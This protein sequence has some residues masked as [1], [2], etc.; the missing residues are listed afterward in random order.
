MVS[1]LGDKRI[2]SDSSS[3][4]THHRDVDVS[5]E[6]VGLKMAKETDLEQKIALVALSCIRANGIL[7]QKIYGE[8]WCSIYKEIDCP[9][10]N[11]DYGLSMGKGKLYLGCKYKLK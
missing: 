3:G 7:Q 2:A 10:Q 8:Y 11:K 4:V 1:Y 6:N 5:E 9:Y